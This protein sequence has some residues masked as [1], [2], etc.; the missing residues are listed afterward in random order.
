MRRFLIQYNPHRVLRQFGFDQ[1]VPDINATRCP[2]SDAM[3]PLVHGTTMKYWAS[4]VERVLVPS[5]HREGY[6]TSNMQLYWR[7]VMSTFVDYVNSREVEQVVISPPLNEPSTNA[8]LIP[9]TRV[10]LAWVPR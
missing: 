3:K 6:A 2:L 5:R 4:K 7:K 1:D 8:R 9:N 10:A